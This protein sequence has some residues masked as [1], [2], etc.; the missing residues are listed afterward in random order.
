[1]SIRCDRA[2]FAGGA[3]WCEAMRAFVRKPLSFLH[4]PRGCFAVSLYHPPGKLSLCGLG[5]FVVRHRCW[6]IYPSA[7]ILT[8][9]FC[10]SSK[11]NANTT[12]GRGVPFLY[13]FFHTL[14]SPL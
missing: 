12:L 3:G 5:L 7:Y 11:K 10:L 4:R 2:I 1:M 13:P 14:P 8:T 6:H 9:T